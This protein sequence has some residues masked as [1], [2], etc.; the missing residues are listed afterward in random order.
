GYRMLRRELP[1]GWDHGLPAF[2]ADAKGMATRDASSQVLNVVAKNVPWLV[3]GSADPAPSCN[4][5]LAFDQAG[6]F[7][8]ENP[9][10]RNLHFGIREHAMRAMLNGLALSKIRPF[11]SGLLVFSDYAR[12]S[13]R[14]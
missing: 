13:R 12:T 5:R 2:P 11:G 4:T 8:A 14:L 7:S 10:G 1:D 3:G 9:A 6:D